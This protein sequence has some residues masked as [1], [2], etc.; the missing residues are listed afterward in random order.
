MAALS[1]KAKPANMTTTYEHAILVTGA[2]GAVGGIGRN[3]TKMLLGR[4]HK[5]RAMVRQEDARAE[6]L[7]GLGAKVVVGD[8]TDLAAVAIMSKYHFLRTFRRIVGVTPYEH[9]LGSRAAQTALAENYV[10]R[11]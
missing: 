10:G 3:V 8:L 1:P 9:L 11:L 4:G 6:A 2:G 5:V 7:R